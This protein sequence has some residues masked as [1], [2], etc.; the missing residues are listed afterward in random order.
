V[1]QTKRTSQRAQDLW[2]L[3]MREGQSVDQVATACGI[4]RA[5]LERLLIA[6]GK[7]QA[8]SLQN[9]P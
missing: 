8:R 3:V 5:R 4:A 9:Q 2:R 1:Q 6:I 7:R